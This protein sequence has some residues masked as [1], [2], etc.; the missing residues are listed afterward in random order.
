MWSTPPSSLISP[1]DPALATIAVGVKAHE[2][3]VSPNGRLAYVP[4]Y[5]NSG[6]GRPG[7]DVGTID[8]INLRQRKLVSAFHLPKSDGL[9]CV[10]KL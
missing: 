9:D 2:L 8:I 7:A 6:V 4:I 1:V 10:A 3:P 5:G